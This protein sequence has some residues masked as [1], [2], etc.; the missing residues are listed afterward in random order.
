MLATLTCESESIGDFSLGS[1]RSRQ[2]QHRGTLAH[3]QAREQHHMPV[4]EFQRV[5][6]GH[7]GMPRPASERV[8]DDSENESPAHLQIAVGPI[9]KYYR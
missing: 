4:R 2:L 1:G 8:F 3:T 5:V 6:M 7:T 9:P